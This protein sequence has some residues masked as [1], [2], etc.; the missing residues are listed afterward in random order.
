MSVE[1][2][3]HNDDR[4][5]ALTSHNIKAREHP[6]LQPLDTQDGVRVDD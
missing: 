3:K 6:N 1:N 2:N 5:V 4:R